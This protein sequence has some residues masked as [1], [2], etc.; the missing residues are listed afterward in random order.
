M[1][2]EI[3]QQLLREI[4]GLLKEERLDKFVDEHNSQEF[5][6]DPTC[7]YFQEEAYEEEKENIVKKYKAIED[8]INK[9]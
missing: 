2:K 8:L 6:E 5:E 3:L 9:L 1:N 4:V 7:R